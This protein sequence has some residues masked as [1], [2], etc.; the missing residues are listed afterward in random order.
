MAGVNGGLSAG[1]GSPSSR[2]TNRLS[3]L[4]QGTNP[5]EPKT[6]QGE[7]AQAQAASALILDRCRLMAGPRSLY[8]YGERLEYGTS[9]TTLLTAITAYAVALYDIL[10][11]AFLGP[12]RELNLP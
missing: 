9:V 10:P 3:I 2:D 12:V 6:G 4:P 5:T 11:R 8:A 1:K 7:L